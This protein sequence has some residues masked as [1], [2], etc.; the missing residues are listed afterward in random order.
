MDD[1]EDGRS[2]GGTLKMLRQTRKVPAT[3]TEANEAQ[4]C[5]ELEALIAQVG[6]AFA[7]ASAQPPLTPTPAAQYQHVVEKHGSESKEAR[8]VEDLISRVSR[9]KDDLG[10]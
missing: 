4:V 8:M 9:A 6:R 1:G 2:V 5:E 3:D 10:V 7:V